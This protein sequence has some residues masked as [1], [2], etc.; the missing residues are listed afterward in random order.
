M[1]FKFVATTRDVVIFIIF[2]IFL[3]Y[4]VALGVLN[5]PE[6]ASQGS[7]YGL[8]PLEA[9]SPDYIYYT[10]VLYFIALFGLFMSVNSYFFE[11][12]EGIGVKIGDKS[13]GG[14]SRWAKAKEIKNDTDV[15]KVETN[16][17]KSDYAGVPLISNGTE[18]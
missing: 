9:F 2:A 1:K 7:F 10:L 16:A 8:N 13:G 3:L 11:F 4:V 18:L 15:K 17:L 14:Y 12:E 6:L 5:I